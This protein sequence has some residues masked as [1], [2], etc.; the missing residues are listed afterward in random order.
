MAR[1]DEKRRRTLGG[2]GLKSCMRACARMRLPSGLPARVQQSHRSNNQESNRR[3]KRAQ[4][5]GVYRL[6]GAGGRVCRRRGCCCG[7]GLGW[8]R[9]C[10]TARGLGRW[11]RRRFRC[12]RLER[13]RRSPVISRGALERCGL[14]LAPCRGLCCHL[15]RWRGLYCR[16]AIGCCSGLWRWSIRRLRGQGAGGRA[17]MRCVATS[18]CHPGCSATAALDVLHHQCGAYRGWG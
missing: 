2:A 14:L 8:R 1:T 17:D 4:S 16:Q 13:C 7:R 18:G 9:G 15:A 10:C 6:S 12:G 3:V 5:Q 11:G